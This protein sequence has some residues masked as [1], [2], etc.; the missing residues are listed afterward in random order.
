MQTILGANGVISRERSRQL[1]TYATRIR[2]VSRVPAGVNPADERVSAN[3]RDAK[4]TS[5]AVE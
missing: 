1:P 2:Q 3:L 5:D 4:A